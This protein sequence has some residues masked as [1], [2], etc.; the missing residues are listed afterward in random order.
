MDHM[1]V[2]GYL[3]LNNCLYIYIK[4]Q[5]RRLVIPNI[6]E[7]NIAKINF[8]YR[9]LY[10]YT[11]KDRVLTYQ[12][13][14]GYPISYDILN[15]ILP[16]DKIFNYFLFKNDFSKTNSLCY[17]IT[18]YFSDFTTFIGDVAIWGDSDIIGYSTIEDSI[19]FNTSVDS[20]VVVKSDT[21]ATKKFEVKDDDGESNKIQTKSDKKFECVFVKVGDK[22]KI[23]IIKTGIQDDT[24]IE[25]I[26]GLSKGDVVITG[27]YTTVTKDLNSGDKVKAK[28]NTP[29]KAKGKK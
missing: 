4:E 2:D 5:Y 20:S 12:D 28:I 18:T 27:P 10:L 9:D 21:T 17:S 26:S 7:I 8:N 1:F 25:V 3:F 23:K 15:A 22:A 24:N 16:T 6:Q 29:A 11:S 14:N 19:I 13:K